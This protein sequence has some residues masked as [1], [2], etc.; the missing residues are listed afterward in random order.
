MR[1]R[2][3]PAT[4]RIRA[5]IAHS[6]AIPERIIRNLFSLAWL[7]TAVAGLCIRSR[8]IVYR[9]TDGGSRGGG[10]G[11]G[12]ERE[13]SGC[14]ALEVEAVSRIHGTAERATAEPVG[15]GR[16][17]GQSDVVRSVREYERL[18]ERTLARDHNRRD[19]HDDGEHDHELN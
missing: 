2:A 15:L 1:I 7:I 18:I 4:E 19:N 10:I 13:R 3:G 5:K 16:A 8:R 17:Q 14:A 11:I 9:M 6:D 12:K